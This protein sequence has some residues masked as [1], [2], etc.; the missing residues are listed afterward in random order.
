MESNLSGTQEKYAELLLFTCYILRQ[1]SNFK[2]H[3]I[4]Y[5]IY[6]FFKRW[7]YNVRSVEDCADQELAT[8]VE[9]VGE[10]GR[11]RFIS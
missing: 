1:Y 7:E 9:Y 3:P 6:S 4:A 2:G 10:K 8:L 11:K 5:S